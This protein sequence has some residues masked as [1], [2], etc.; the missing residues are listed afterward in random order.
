M[1]QIFESTF[2]ADDASLLERDF[3]VILRTSSA[4]IQPYL[5]PVTYAVISN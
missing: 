2:L 5:Q 4:L 3:S 1:R